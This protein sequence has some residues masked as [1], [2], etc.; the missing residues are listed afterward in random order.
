MRSIGPAKH[1]VKGHALHTVTLEFEKIEYHEVLDQFLHQAIVWCQ[2]DHF[3][4]VC[5]W[6]LLCM[7]MIYLIEICILGKIILLFQ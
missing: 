7:V 4:M 5:C 2:F 1:S 3:S 6:A